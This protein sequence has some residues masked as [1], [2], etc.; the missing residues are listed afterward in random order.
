M[1]STC[2]VLFVV[3]PAVLTSQCTLHVA[4]KSALRP[5]WLQLLTANCSCGLALSPS[6]SLPAFSPSLMNDSSPA[7]QTDAGQLIC[8]IYNSREKRNNLVLPPNDIIQLGHQDVVMKCTGS[9]YIYPELVVSHIRR[10]CA[11]SCFESQKEIICEPKYTTQKINDC[12]LQIYTM[13]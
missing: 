9:I 5:P 13:Q 10:G 7:A 4:A 2:T 8:S 12:Y 11:A 6:P 1:P 3:P